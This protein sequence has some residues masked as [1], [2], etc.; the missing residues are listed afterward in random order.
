VRFYKSEK[1]AQA[2]LYGTVSMEMGAC[3]AQDMLIGKR[4][5]TG[6]RT[7]RL[8]EGPAVL[9]TATRMGGAQIMF[10]DGSSGIIG[11]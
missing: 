11:K 4:Y 7:G 5:F 3:V 6:Q 2:A 10:G 1:E 8:C 9:V